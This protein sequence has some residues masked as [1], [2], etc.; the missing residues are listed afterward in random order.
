[1]DAYKRIMDAYKRTLEAYK[2]IV[3]AYKTIV[4]AYI[5]WKIKS[6]E[7]PFMLCKKEWEVKYE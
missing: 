7:N 5:T 6:Y 4:D 1:M 2:I 3:E